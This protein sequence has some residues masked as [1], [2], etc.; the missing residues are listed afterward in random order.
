MLVLSPLAAFLV[1]FLLQGKRKMKLYVQSDYR[2][3]FNI[4]PAE[5]SIGVIVYT[6]QVSGALLAYTGTS[7]KKSHYLTALQKQ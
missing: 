6:L 1:N 3:Q 2:I 4:P 5:G 7:L